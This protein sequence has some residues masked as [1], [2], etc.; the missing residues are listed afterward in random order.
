[1]GKKRRLV[2]SQK[3]SAKHS[4]HPV[5]GGSSAIITTSTTDIGIPT[6]PA[7]VEVQSIKTQSATTTV[8]TEIIAKV[9]DPTPSTTTKNV[10]TTTT[11]ATKTTAAKN[12]VKNSTKTSKTTKSTRTTARKTKSSTNKSS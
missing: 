9:E 7:S 6:P 2:S 4:S 8:P 12:V 1:M 10:E 3:F 11:K 5:L